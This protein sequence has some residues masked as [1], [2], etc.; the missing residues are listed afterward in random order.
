VG[1]A[2]RDA[3]LKRKVIERDWAVVGATPQEMLDL[4]YTQVGKDFPVFLHPKTKEEYA[5][6][7]TERKTANGYT[8]FTCVTGPQVSLEDDLLRR[9]LT[10]NAIAQDESGQ[11]I[12]PFGGQEDLK[13]GI[14]RHVSPAFSE[15]PLRV[16]RVARFAARYHYLGFTIAEETMALMTKMCHQGDIDALSPHRVWQETRRSLMEASPTVYFSVLK[17]V[18]ALHY[19]MPELETNLTQENIHALTLSANKEH[20]LPIRWA[21]LCIPLPLAQV[22]HLCTRLS[23]PNL[24]TEVAHLAC[25]FAPVFKQQAMSAQQMLDVFNKADAWRRPERFAEIIK[26]IDNYLPESMEVRVNQCLQSA[27]A[28]DV[29]AILKNGHTGAAIKQQLQVQRLA[30]IEQNLLAN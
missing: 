5:L 8:G 30:V 10:V 11:L 6:A 9:D 7:R 20:S 18:G 27:N 29:K 28:I 22:S 3:L 17:Q 12:D 2:V 24:E 16:F 13:Q 26:S 25:Q 14:L 19:W 23:V 21:S 4:G 1:G 15:D